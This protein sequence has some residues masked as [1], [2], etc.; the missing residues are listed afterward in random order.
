MKDRNQGEKEPPWYCHCQMATQD[1]DTIMREAG[2]SSF[3]PAPSSHHAGASSHLPSVHINNGL[4]HSIAPPL[5]GPASLPPR[6]PG[7]YG[8]DTVLG[9]SNQK[10]PPTGG[11]ARPVDS[12]PMPLGPFGKVRDKLVEENSDWSEEDTMIPCGLPLASLSTGLCY[13][14]RMRY[15]CE[16]RPTADVHPED[17]RRIYYIYKELCRAGLVDDPDSSRPLAPRP[18]KRIDVRNATLE[19][20]SLVH[21]REHFAFVESTK[22]IYP[23]NF[24]ILPFV[25]SF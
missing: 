9:S 3:N 22:G 25:L 7:T 2:P 14:I 19:E 24:S 16:V 10:A 6:Q 11:P 15:H 18:M 23:V 5:L 1:E 12:G 17:P 13:D 8:H 20:I 21:T 4:E